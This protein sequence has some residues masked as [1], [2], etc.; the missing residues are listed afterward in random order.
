MSLFREYERDDRKSVT[1]EFEGTAVSVTAEITVAAA[2][3]KLVALV[4]TTIHRVPLQRGI[5]VIQSKM[6]FANRG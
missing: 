3:H 2:A 6:P 5:V 4:E 1:V